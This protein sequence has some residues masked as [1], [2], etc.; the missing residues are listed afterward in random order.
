M[1]YTIRQVI[2]K[3]S[4]GQVRIP[5]FQRGFVWEPEMVAYLMDSIYK[6]ESVNHR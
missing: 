4:N 1:D 2:E 3:V 6:E 5:T